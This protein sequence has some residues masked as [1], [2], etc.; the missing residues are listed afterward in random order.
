MRAVRFYAGGPPMFDPFNLAMLAAESQQVVSL[1]LWKLAWGGSAGAV[2]AFGMVA[3]KMHAGSEAAG[4][5][6]A[7]A[8]FD[9]VVT[10][11]RT[12]V[13]ANVRRLTA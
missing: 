12:T 11:Y 8:T 2:E 1:R 7:G 10:D 9:S 3:E 4:R 5:L 6:M 13:Q